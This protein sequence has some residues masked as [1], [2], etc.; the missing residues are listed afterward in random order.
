MESC[1]S[2]RKMLN[3]A[4][5]LAA[6]C[7]KKHP[8]KFSRMNFTQ[9]QL[10]ACLVFRGTETGTHLVLAGADE[11]GSVD[12]QTA[13]MGGGAT[14]RNSVDRHGTGKT[15]IEKGVSLVFVSSGR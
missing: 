3:A 2:P 10:F 4:Y 1:K 8:S 14:R 7:L 11:F 15:G 5:V 9:S 6:A 13:G 12:G